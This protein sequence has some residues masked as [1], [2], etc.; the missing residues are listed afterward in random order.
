MIKDRENLTRLEKVRRKKGLT[1]IQLVR[2]SGVSKATIQ[3]LEDSS[4]LFDD[5]KLST[6]IK[7]SKALRVKP[8]EILPLEIAKKIK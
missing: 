2:L 3:K 1:R 8:S 7:L 5:I 4:Y 6:L